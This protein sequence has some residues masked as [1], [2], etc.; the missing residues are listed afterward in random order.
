MA[1][2]AS[3]GGRGRDAAFPTFGKATP[4]SLLLKGIAQFGPDSPKC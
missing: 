3:F 1:E 2:L 4:G